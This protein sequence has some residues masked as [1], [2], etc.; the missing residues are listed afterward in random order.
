MALNIQ[1]RRDDS[2]GSPRWDVKRLQ[3]LLRTSAPC[4]VLLLQSGQCGAND[5]GVHGGIIAGYQTGVRFH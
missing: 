4:S 3:A 5:V 1:A 2:H